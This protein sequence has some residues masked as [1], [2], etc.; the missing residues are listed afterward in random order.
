MQP[1]LHKAGREV[2]GAPKGGPLLR[3]SEEKRENG[4]ASWVG[5]TVEKEQKEGSER[6]WSE[7]VWRR[8]W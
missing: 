7:Q 4:E 5:C 3:G 6:L 8:I 2:V 1:G